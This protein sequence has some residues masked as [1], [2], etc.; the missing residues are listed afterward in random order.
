MVSCLLKDGSWDWVVMGLGNFF[1]EAV[2]VAGRWHGVVV[3]FLARVGWEWVRG[4]GGSG[5]ISIAVETLSVRMRLRKGLSLTRDEAVR[6]E[7]IY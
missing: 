4:R 6:D 7:F 2:G 5:R 3:A 1:C